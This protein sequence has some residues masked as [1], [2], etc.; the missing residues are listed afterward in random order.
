MATGFEKFMRAA[1]SAADRLRRDHPE[2]LISKTP[3][4]A[5][6]EPAE[7]DAL[8][9]WIAARPEPKPSRSE[10]TRLLIAE[11]LVAK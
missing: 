9:A 2:S 8:D 10:A 4:V 5:M 6:L 1:G 7:L 3:V 11:A